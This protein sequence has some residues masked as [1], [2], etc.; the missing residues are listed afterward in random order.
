ME[1]ISKKTIELLN[2]RINQ[3][4]LTSK[5]Y[6][7]MYL[8]LQNNTYLNAAV[9]WK[10][11]YE[12]ELIHAGWAKDYLMS[13][14]IMPELEII[15]EP[16]NM[17][18]SFNEIVE[19]TLELEIRTTTQCRELA[20]HALEEG[21]YNLLILANK[22]NEEQIEELDTAYNFMDLIK[23]TDDKLLIENYIKENFIE[24]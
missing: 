5:M 11:N 18:N 22:Y 13:F 17:Y 9:V 15:P 23:M 14:N 7:Q 20:K 2:F 12:D 10:Q 21:D 19:K 8:W 16:Q 1:L 6:E 4:Q 3:E 24:N